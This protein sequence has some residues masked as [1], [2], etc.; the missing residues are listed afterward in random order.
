MLINILVV[1][2]TAIVLVFV[3]IWWFVP[4]LRSSIEAPKYP[5]ADW[6]VDPRSR[7]HEPE[8]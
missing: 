2:I 6:D 3:G 8:A 1:S 4:A 5:V 7:A